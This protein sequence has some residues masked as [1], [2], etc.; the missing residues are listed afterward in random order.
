[1]SFNRA[2]PLKHGDRI[3]IIAPSSP[4]ERAAWDKGLDLLRSWGFEPVYSED[5]FTTSGYLSGDDDRRAQEFIRAYNAPDTSAVWCSRGG[6][7]ASRL[8]CQ[9]DACDFSSPKLF[10]GFSDITALHI[11]LNDSCKTATLHGPVITSLGKLP[12]ASKNLLKRLLTETAP[13]GKI[14]FPEPL[15]VLA[16]G[17]ARGRL[18]G[19]NLSLLTH[20]I[21]TPWSLDLKDRLLFIEEVGEGPYR[22]DRMLTQL[23]SSANLEEVRGII[24]GDFLCGYDPDHP[25]QDDILLHEV[26][27]ERLGDLGIPVIAGLPSGHGH[28]NFSLPLGVEVFMDS[29]E[30]RIVLEESL[31]IVPD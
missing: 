5:V 8:L 18:V 14:E 22:V 27:V 10:I 6:Y 13:V 31:L 17:T 9:L 11:F 25:H 3:S 16:P 4:F 23:R 20:L 19:G 28:E 21:G 15:H 7:G 24:C 30:G 26:L 1:M 2:A 29:A 12:S